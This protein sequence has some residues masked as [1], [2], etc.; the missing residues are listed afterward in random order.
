MSQ[1]FRRSLGT[2]TSTPRDKDVSVLN[3]VRFRMRF[4]SRLL[5]NHVDDDRRFHVV[6]TSGW[7]NTSRVGPT[8]TPRKHFSRN[9]LLP[10]DMMHLSYMICILSMGMIIG[11][12][13]GP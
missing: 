7:H 6:G 1:S 3:L 10:N 2:D 8:E 9:A 11:K 4:D 12:G 5:N 13:G